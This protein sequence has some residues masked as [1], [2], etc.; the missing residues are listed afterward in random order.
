MIHS[1]VQPT[2]QIWIV[3]M[4]FLGPS[5]DRHMERMPYA[6]TTEEKCEEFAR[7]VLGAHYKKIPG[8]YFWCQDV[9]VNQKP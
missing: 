5:G 9:P 6:C 2:L 1:V 4:T 7:P 3:V 8:L